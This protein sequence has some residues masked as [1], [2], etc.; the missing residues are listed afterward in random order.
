MVIIPIYRR[1]FAPSPGCVKYESIIPPLVGDRW[2]KQSG[3]R[4]APGIEPGSYPPHDLTTY[5]LPLQ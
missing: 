5:R 4:T 3:G 1:T 2:D